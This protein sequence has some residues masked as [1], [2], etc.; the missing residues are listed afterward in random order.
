MLKIRL[1]DRIITSFPSI[2]SSLTSPFVIY[3]LNWALFICDLHH[4]GVKWLQIYDSIIP[5]MNFI[6]AGSVISCYY[7]FLERWHFNGLTV[8]CQSTCLFNN[9]CVWKWTSSSPQHQIP[10]LNE[11]KIRWNPNYIFRI[12]VCTT[13][14]GGK[15]E[16]MCPV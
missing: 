6:Y 12:S 10:F 2:T 14:E 13:S 7:T 8:Q 9:S 16:M 4:S 11:F 1:A 3:T 5:P 15:M